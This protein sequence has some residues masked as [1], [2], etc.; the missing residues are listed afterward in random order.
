MAA[1]QCGKFGRWRGEGILDVRDEILLKTT[2]CLVVV[3]VVEYAQDDDYDNDLDLEIS[4][5]VRSRFA[6]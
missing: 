2:T 5:T 6:E 3:V 1:L 4:S